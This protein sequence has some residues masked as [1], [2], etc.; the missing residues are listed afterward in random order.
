VAGGEVQRFEDFTETLETYYDM[1]K[2]W[3]AGKGFIPDT[4]RVDRNLYLLNKL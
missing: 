3:Q 1:V 2:G 4:F